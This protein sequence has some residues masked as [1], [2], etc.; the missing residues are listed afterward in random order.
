MITLDFDDGHFPG[1]D[2]SKKTKLRIQS[3]KLN[4]R[5]ISV[6]DNLTDEIWCKRAY[7]YAMIKSRPWGVYITRDD[8]LSA[9]A[10]DFFLDLDTEKAIALH[11]VRKL[12]YGRASKTID[13]D[14]DIIHGTVVWCL[15]S[16]EHS[17]VDYHI[18][19]EI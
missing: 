8:A 15:Q 16:A 1:G 11:F 10:D 9:L 17:S 3:E 14:L 13:K 7:D 6:Y 19:I 5:F 2:E 18:G 4:P 12:I